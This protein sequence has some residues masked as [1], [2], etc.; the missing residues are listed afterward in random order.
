MIDYYNA[1]ISYRHAELDSKVAEDVQRSLEHFVVPRAIQKKIGKK[2]IERIFRDKDELPITS[3][4]TDTISNALEKADYLIVICSP[5]T[6]ESFWVQREIEFFLKNHTKN[7]ILTVLAGGE[8]NEVIP[9]ILKSDEKVIKEADG[10]EHTITVSKEPLSCDYRMPFRRAHKEEIPRLAAAVL[11][12]SY[13]E[14]VRRQ[15][16]YKARRLIALSAGVAAAALVFGAYMW[17]SKRQVS[18]ALRQ[19]NIEKSR[20]LAIQSD[21]LLEEEHRLDAIYLGL[22][23]MPDDLNDTEA[24]TS[25]AV[26]SL[27]Y[28]TNA[29]RSMAGSNVDSVWNYNT[30]APAT[31]VAVNEDGTRMAAID[32]LGSV[33]V[34]DTDSHEL[35]FTVINSGVLNGQMM[36]VDGDKLL[37]L[38]SDSLSA[39]D[40][41]TGEQ[42]WCFESTFE[43]DVT[44]FVTS[45]IQVLQ[46]G[47]VMLCVSSETLVV[48]DTSDGSIVDRYDV[49]QN[50]EGMPAS[51]SD[52]MVSPDNSKVAFTIYNG[53][54]S[55]S[56]SVYD[57]RTGSL[58]HADDIN[59]YISDLTWYD[60]DRFVVSAYEFG[61]SE[62]SVFLDTFYM[63]PNNSIVYCFDGDDLNL[64][65]EAPHV[66][67]G[68]STYR[69][70]IT[71]PQ[72]NSVA[73][74]NG[75]SL[76]AYDID[77]GSVLN[78]WVTNDS[79]V[80]VSD[81]DGDGNPLIITSGGG[82]A[83]PASHMGD[84]VLGLNY[85]FISDIY[86]AVVNHGVYII[87]DYSNE[88][89]Y[90]N[91]HVVDEEWVQTDDVLTESCRDYYMDEEVLAVMYGSTVTMIDPNTNELID[92]V[93]L[94]NSEDNYYNLNL[95]GSYD[96]NLY[97][98]DGG[99]QGISLHEIDIDRGTVDQIQ[100]FDGYSSD[101]NYASLEDGKVFY[102][103]NSGSTRQF[104]IYD[105]DS[106]DTDEY[107]L[108]VELLSDIPICPTY[109]DEMGIIYV[110]SHTGDYMINTEDERE[111]RLRLPDEWNDTITVTADVVNDHVIVADGGQ[112][113][114]INSSGDIDYSIS[115]EGNRPLGIDIVANEADGTRTMLVAYSN[116]TLARYNPATYELEGVIDIST[117]EDYISD[118][119]F[120]VDWENNYLYIQFWMLTDVI[121]MNTMVEEAAVENCFG[122]HL[123][124]DRFYTT[125]YSASDERMIGYFRHYTV[126][127]LV[128][129]AYAILG[130]NT[131]MPEDLRVRY[132]L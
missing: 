54:N 8:P 97:V 96:G 126:Q 78:D 121:N 42:L 20:Y 112:I 49:S 71:L 59:L 122:H 3:D 127:E 79:I 67:V 18:E 80:D 73:F 107:E 104:C 119:Q 37:L 110:A 25:E 22:A 85:E 68:Y 65:W 77:N 72:N 35:L 46:N 90:Y 60:D 124:T 94:Y 53:F 40:S 10:T 30:N 28:A 120:Q 99:G 16:A 2:K 89:I 132:G 50:F 58:E 88:I 51:Y 45:P 33:F 36:F 66:S 21:M 93:T 29:Y 70:F 125:S 23:A 41:T 105:I 14:L 92:E 47:N 103:R 4:L 38:A 106:G 117:Y 52:F 116:G 74:Y 115:T 102:L 62:S 75:A 1:F 114:F 109:I 83:L 39:Y 5:N 55:G 81:R 26:S 13:D 98:I 17:N 123:E 7:E 9:E 131:E 113:L 108:N 69:D 100:I 6:C 111:I 15:R 128:D 32:T 76:T 43:D 31:S 61:S 64:I 48:I 86:N 24:V 84:N 11:G 87:R 63:S 12:C 27:V 34:W 57:I 19:A 44:L 130:D 95:L 101:M 129:R 56:V 118:V 82:L 91:S